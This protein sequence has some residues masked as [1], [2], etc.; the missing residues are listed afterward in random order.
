M[1]SKGIK[2][3]FTAEIWKY[4]GPAGWYFISLPVKLAKEIR[5]NLKLQEGGWGRLK[6]IAQIG[7]S[8]W[9]TA[10]WFDTKIKTYLLPIKAE[11]RNK[12]KLKDGDR[13]QVTVWV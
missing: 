12:E 10:I 9:K 11:I 3:V 8:E 1:I 13:K 5:E 6:A 2:Y 7:G 4:S